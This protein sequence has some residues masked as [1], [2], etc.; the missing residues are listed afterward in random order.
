[1]KLAYFSGLK[2]NLSDRRLLRNQKQRHLVGYK[3]R[4]IRGLFVGHGRSEHYPVIEASGLEKSVI[5]RVQ[6]T[7]HPKHT[8]QQ[9]IISKNASS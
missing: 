6:E 2:I 8:M 9:S 4:M 1:M 7:L 3:C 5:F